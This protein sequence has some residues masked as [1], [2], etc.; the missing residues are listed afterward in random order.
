MSADSRCHIE[1]VLKA[2]HV[3]VT[4]EQHSC[5]LLTQ[6]MVSDSSSQS[7]VML[8]TFCK[9]PLGPFDTYEALCH[10]R[11]LSPCERHFVTWQPGRPS[12]T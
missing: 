12:V 4:N 7:Y 9:K 2:N 11:R 3:Q 5:G 10:A 6:E 8:E 1:L